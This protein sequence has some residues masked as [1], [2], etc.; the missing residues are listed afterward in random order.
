MK[1]SGQVSFSP[2]RAMHV[3]RS[4]SLLACILTIDLDYRVC[5]NV[6]EQV[7]KIWKII[8]VDLDLVDH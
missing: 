6:V 5:K 7:Y 3:Q 2:F 1:D 8:Y 4:T